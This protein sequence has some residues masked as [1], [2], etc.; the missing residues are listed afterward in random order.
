VEGNSD[1]TDGLIVNLDA[2]LNRIGWSGELKTDPETLR[3]L[4]L[5]HTTSIPF[6]NLDIQLGKNISLDLQDLQRKLIENRRGG[7]CFEQNTLFHAILK[8]IGFDVIACEAR[9][10]MGRTIASPRTH[11]L[12]VVTWKGERLLVDAGFG[13]DGLLIPVPMDG[14]E[15]QQY[16]W[17]YR[18]IR[19]GDLF[20]LQTFRDQSWMDLY[21]FV[22][23][24]RDDIDFQVANWY[25]STHPDSR[26]VQTLTVQLPTPEARYI[27]RN[28][29]ASIQR[30]DQ[31]QTQDL[32]SKQELINLL[33]EIFHLD[34]SIDTP[35]RNP[36]F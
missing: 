36:V 6:E 34:F 23:Q 25:T 7:Y 16:L 13:G 35:F 21:A 29:T 15:H 14:A 9:V 27:V 11:M 8:E 32:K 22:A 30:G 26:F 33:A 19:D 18:V 1:S 17:K 2:Y 5:K 24:H 4:H 12:L 3:L 31:I 20:V 28:R 10:R